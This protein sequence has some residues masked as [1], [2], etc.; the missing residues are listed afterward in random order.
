MEVFVMSESVK[1]RKM[2]MPAAVGTVVMGLGAAV[3][4]ILHMRQPA[5]VVV[6]TPP[7]TKVVERIVHVPAPATPPAPPAPPPVLPPEPKPEPNP[8]ET[9][10]LSTVPKEKNVWEG[11]WRWNESPLPMFKVS[12]DGD[13]LAGTC[14]ANWGTVVAWRN[15]VVTGNVLEFVVDEDISRVHVRMTM[16]AEGKSKVEQWVTD[17]DWMVSLERANKGAKTPLQRRAIKAALL[18]NAQKFR[19]PVVIGIFTRQGD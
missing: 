19:K 2:F 9:R 3:L 17:N 18:Q 14:A 5:P 10:M 15:G 11:G 12:Q 1:E 7:E 4:L 16:T 8:V 13:G 6:K